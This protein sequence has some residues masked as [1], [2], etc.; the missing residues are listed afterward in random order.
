V[1]GFAKRDGKPAAGAMVLLAPKNPAADRE[2]FRRDQSNSDGSFSLNRVIPGEYTVIAI[3]DGWTLD[4]A[5]P[6]V[7]AHYL[8]NGQKLI[9]S[10]RGK[11]VAL[12]DPVEV[13]SK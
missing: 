9:V 6:E 2:M 11:D 7:I 3:E 12:A 10:P 4:W 13:Q 8:A 1:T 5:R